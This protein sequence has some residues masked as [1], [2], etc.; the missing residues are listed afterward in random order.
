MNALNLALFQWIAGGNQPAGVLG[1]ASA[2]ALWGSWLSAGSSSLRCGGN[3]PTA[4][5]CASLPR[6]QVHLA[7]GACHRDISGRAPALRAGLSPAYIP[8]SAG[9]ARCRARTQP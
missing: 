8:H 9:A 5:G 7:A 3:P 2:F 1:V 6:R 4:P